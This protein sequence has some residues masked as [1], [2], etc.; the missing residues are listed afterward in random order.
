[1]RT[2]LF[3]MILCA[4]HS[5]NTISQ[6]RSNNYIL[7]RQLLDSMCINSISTTEY[8]NGLGNVVEIVTNGSGTGESTYSTYQYDGKGRVSMSYLP[9]PYMKGLNYI[10]P[11]AIRQASTQFYSGDSAAFSQTLYDSRD[12]IIS[13]T[14]PGKEWHQTDATNKTVYSYNTTSDLVLHY[15]AKDD[16]ISP[17]LYTDKSLR[18]YHPG[19]LDKVLN[20]DTDGHVTE[21]YTDLTGKMVLRRRGNCDTY[22]VYNCRGEL[23]FI[24]QPMYQKEASVT[25]YAFRYRYNSLGDMIEKATPGCEPIRYWYDRYHRRIFEQDGEL[26]AKSLFRFT[27]SDR[28]GRPS[29]RGLCRWFD[30]DLSQTDMYT[31][32]VSGP[33]GFLGT[34]NIISN[35][36]TIHT[37]GAI[38]EQLYFYDNYYFINGMYRNEFKA[39]GASQRAYGEGR[40]TGCVSRASNGELIFSVYY[41]D[42]RGNL[43]ETLESGL[44]KYHTRTVRTYTFTDHP[45]S[46]TATANVGYGKPFSANTLYSYNQYNDM[47]DSTTVTLSHGTFPRSTQ[48]VFQ[49]DPLNRTILQERGYG[50]SAVSTSYDMHGWTKHIKS[51]TFSETLHYTDGT[52][53]PYFNGNISS[54]E[55]NSGDMSVL[56]G[57]RFGYDALDQMTR[58]HYGEGENLS[59]N[60]GR[61]DELLQYD[62]N[63]NTTHLMRKGR[64]ASGV[65]GYIDNVDV[66]FNGNRIFRTSDRAGNNIVKGAMDVRNNTTGYSV[67]GY[68]TNGALTFDTGRGISNIKYDN[69]GY[70][71]RV[72]FANGNVTKY[73]YTSDGRK[74]RTIHITAMPNIRVS[75]GFNHELSDEQIDSRDSI[76][77]LLDGNLILKN[78]R[79]DKFLFDGGYSQA[80]PKSNC[81]ARPPYPGG[82]TAPSDKDVDLFDFRFFTYDHLGNV[83]DVIDEDGKVIQHNDYYPFGMPYTSDNYTVNPDLQQYKYNGKELD[84]IHGLNTYDYGERQYW[85]GMNIWNK[86]DNMAEAHPELSPYIYCRNNSVKLV[87]NDGND[88]NVYTDKNNNIVIS[89][90]IYCTNNDYEAVKQGAAFWI[91]QNGKF[92]YEGRPV[93]FDISINAINPKEIAEENNREFLTDQQALQITYQKDQSG[94]A[95][96]FMLVDKFDKNENGTITLGDTS[97]HRIRVLRERAMTST[98]THEI[99]H[100]LGFTHYIKGVMTPASNA[101]NRNL[102][103]TQKE[104]IESINRAKNGTKNKYLGEGHY[105]Y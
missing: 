51:S 81:I 23:C 66:T 21:T 18:Y 39:L 60:S 54:V 73:V 6:T 27:L 104:I 71:L 7:S 87:D 52:G 61:Y 56:R 63:G 43:V 105:I 11:A 55:W 79:I 14:I 12:R 33:S 31:M 76:D 16:S 88:Y 5:L 32:Y 62:K 68:N 84:L 99:G 38:I 36:K 70:P 80:S 50:A 83:R 93:V 44:G 77:Y 3:L 82:A 48:T 92:E 53:T 100:S 95:N 13:T 58:A 46:V 97:K 102:T 15:Y 25:K 26:R 65:F 35:D 72:Q 101:P 90:T 75:A 8:Y 59:N 40:K 1:M 64:N 57:Y 98:V 20:T 19:S 24:L 29:M 89:Q 91:S 74:L 17:I 45:H 67:Y 94:Q 69:C 2:R 9:T 30:G 28:Y 47:T 34:S 86:P 78:S 37:D 41:Y 85:A 49:Y 96:I 42:V 22:Y 10:Q 103:I 4:F